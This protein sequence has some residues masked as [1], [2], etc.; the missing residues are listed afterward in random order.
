MLFIGTTGWDFDHWNGSFY[1]SDSEDQLAYYSKF[2]S[3]TELRPTFFNIPSESLIQEWDAKTPDSFIFTAKMLRNV[4]YNHQLVVKEE[5]IEN[6]FKRLN[7][8]GN[9]LGLVLLQFPIKFQRSP[10]TFEFITGILDKCHELFPGYL[11]VEV[12]NRSWHKEVVK[13]ELATRSACLVSTD[14]RPISATTRNENVYYLRL[15]GDKN[16]VPAKQFGKIELDRRDD[17]KY[18]ANHLKFLNKKHKMVYVAIDNHFSG[19]SAK[20]A[21]ALSK[22]LKRLKVKYEGFRIKIATSPRN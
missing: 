12:R 3:F 7:V 18:W 11:L 8:L 4:T 16:L 10:K 2:A 1:P 5:I 15:M 22:E 14:K 20:D 6:Y 9:K 21:I 13:E 19:N 17:I